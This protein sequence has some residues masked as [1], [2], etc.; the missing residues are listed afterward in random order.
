[1]KSKLLHPLPQKLEMRLKSDP[2]QVA[3]ARRVIEGY[4]EDAGFNPDQVG[5]IGLCVN[6][7]LANVIRH[8]YDDAPEQP[9]HLSAECEVGGDGQT[10]LRMTIRDWGNGEN[11]ADRI[12]AP[13]DP[14]EPGGVGMICLKRLM[15]EVVFCPQPD[16]M[17]LK[18]SKRLEPAA[19]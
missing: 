11:P 12:P 3:D 5:Q 4:A 2:G 18:L 15:D 6:E 17:L 1:M 8:A 16:G 13:R 14:L 10:W 19:P 9:I 7:A